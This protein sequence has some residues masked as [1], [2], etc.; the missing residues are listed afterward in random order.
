MN[1]H[2]TAS[3]KCASDEI[4]I[5]SRCE[6]RNSST[7]SSG[8]SLTASTRL[9]P[10]TVADQAR[11]ENMRKAREAR[12]QKMRAYVNR[13]SQSQKTQ[14]QTLQDAQKAFQQTLSIATSS[15]PDYIADIVKAMRKRKNIQDMDARYDHIISHDVDPPDERGADNIAIKRAVFRIMLNE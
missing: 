10:N 2:E 7:R 12:H 13:H 4:Y 9:K 3:G 5:P 8:S 6:K 11:K 1:K 15:M 14:T